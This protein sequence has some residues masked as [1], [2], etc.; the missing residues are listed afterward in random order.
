MELHELLKYVTE[1]LESLGIQ[2]FV[3]DSIASIFYGEPRFTNDIDIVAD[4]EE[5][6][7]PQLLKSFPEDQFYLS[8]DAISDAIKHRY[9]FNIIHP[10][11]GLKVDIIIRKRDD[12]FD[13]SRF[14]RSRRIS[15]I[16]KN[17]SSL[18]FSRGCDNY[19]DEIL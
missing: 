9:Q 10:A 3:T 14:K 11:S 8:K 13:N 4:I 7:I 6:H 17:H 15:P 16:E 19:E 2:Y 12:E 1:T 18:F 5:K